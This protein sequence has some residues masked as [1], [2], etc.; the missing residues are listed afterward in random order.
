MVN[1]SVASQVLQYLVMLNYA[2]CGS[3]TL[4]LWFVNIMCCQSL[5]FTGFPVIL[6][7]NGTRN[8]LHLDLTRECC[9][10]VEVTISFIYRTLENNFKSASQVGHNT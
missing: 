1:N 3:I 2:N 4:V 10:S 7:L 5:S 8:N 9:S 6:F